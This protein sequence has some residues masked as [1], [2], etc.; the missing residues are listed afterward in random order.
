[1]ASAQAH[2]L[3]Q[4]MHELKEAIRACGDCAIKADLHKNLG[5]IDCQAGNIDEGT[6]ELLIAQRLKPSDPDIEHALALIAQSQA[7]KMQ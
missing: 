2:D 6:R 5:L 4:A 7:G 3:P 1:V